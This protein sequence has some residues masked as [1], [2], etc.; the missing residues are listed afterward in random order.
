MK[1]NLVALAELGQ[2]PWYDNID[3]RLIQSGEF[4]KLLDE[5]VTGVT[6]NP[7]IFEK[8][9][10]GSSVYDQTIEELVKKGYSP[11]EIYDL[12]TIQ[13]IQVAAD[14]LKE[15]YDRTKGQDGYVS[16]EVL[17]RYAQDTEKTIENAR[18]LFK[19]VG[20]DN[21]MIKVPGTPEGEEA[22]RVLTAE[23]INV[24][25]TLLFSLAQYER[26]ARAYIEGLSERLKKGRA[27]DT[28]CSVASVFVSR[29]DTLT[30]KQLEERNN[31]DLQGKIAIANAKIIYQRFKEGF[32][33]EAFSELASKGARIQR[34]LWGS[35]STKNPDYDDLKYVDEL[36]GKETVNTLPHN[37]LLAFLDHGAPKLTLEDNLE[38]EKGYLKALKGLGIDLNANCETLQKQGVR[39]FSDS[40]DQLIDAI[41]AKTR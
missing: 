37:T 12:L 4:K 36:I 28:V 33:G 21:L 23:G 9:I 25:V 18:R 13:D 40:F 39:A 38:H 26:S 16:L 2:S 31:K 1:N 6:S 27:L 29:V 41:A 34:V 14:W 22:I 20:R 5:G 32:K 10:N 3:R 15:T 19:E 11:E 7:S 8:A 30:D 17:P 35:T 24:N